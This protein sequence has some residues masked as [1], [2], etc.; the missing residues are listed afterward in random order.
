M[1]RIAYLMAIDFGSGELRER[2]LADH[3]HSTNPQEPAPELSQ[4]LE[5]ALG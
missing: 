5:K 3:N 1:A 2:T 4:A